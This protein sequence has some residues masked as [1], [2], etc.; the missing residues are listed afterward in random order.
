[1]AVRS[2]ELI[3]AT[4]LTTT[5]VTILPGTGGRTALVKQLFVHNT[6]ASAR[7][8]TLYFNG[9]TDPDTIF[10]RVVQPA[11]TEV[12]SGLCLVVTLNWDL[13]AKGNGAGLVITGFGSYLLGDPA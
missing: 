12:L 3:P 9:S 6:S 2:T 8:V 13:V 10:S 4:V 1:M 7:R 5:P 11:E